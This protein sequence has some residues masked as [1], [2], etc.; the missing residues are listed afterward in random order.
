[1]LEVIEKMLKDI[2]RTIKDTNDLVLNGTIG[3]M[4][5]YR[6]L[7]GRLEGLKFSEEV[8]RRNLKL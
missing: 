3:D 2:Q 6:F 7:M 5:R 8:I 4:E 1:M